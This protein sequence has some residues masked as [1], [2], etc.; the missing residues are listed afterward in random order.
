[1]EAPRRWR[2]CSA[3]GSPT[4]GRL[5]SR[6]VPT[7]STARSR[8]TAKAAWWGPSPSPDLDMQLP[9]RDA[10]RRLLRHLPTFRR[11]P[12]ELWHQAGGER[13][14]DGSLTVPYAEYVPEVEA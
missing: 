1:M 10:I 2:R 12:G 8:D 5:S 13:R 14:S 9:D 6:P 11:P 4:S 7:S 3:A